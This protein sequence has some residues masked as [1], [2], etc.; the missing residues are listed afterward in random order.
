LNGTVL[1]EAEVPT[2]FV[3]FTTF[4]TM[5]EKSN[6]LLDP[7]GRFLP[8]QKNISIYDNTKLFI[9]LDGCVNT[10][11]GECK[12]FAANFGK[13]GKDHTA[14]SR[15]PCYYK[16]VKLKKNKLLNNLV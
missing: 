15:F 8:P 1:P 3:N 4:W 13:D 16:K 7:T 6:R 11:K 14:T 10:L 2:P 12:E 9:N 5:W